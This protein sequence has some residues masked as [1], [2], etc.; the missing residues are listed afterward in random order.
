MPIVT[1]SIDL[2]EC[3]GS[4]KFGV[5]DVKKEADQE[6]IS[7]SS[8]KIDACAQKVKATAEKKKINLVSSSSSSSDIDSDDEPKTKN[9]STLP[10][11]RPMENTKSILDK[12][13]SRTEIPK[14]ASVDSFSES[15]TSSDDEADVRDT[16]LRLLLASKSMGPSTITSSK[17]FRPA[18]SSSDD[19]QKS[20]KPK[21]K[22]GFKLTNDNRPKKPKSIQSPAPV[23]A[24]NFESLFPSNVGVRSST[25]SFRGE[26]EYYCGRCNK[27]YINRKSVLNH[28]AFVHKLTDEKK[29]KILSQSPSTCATTDDSDGHSKKNVRNAIF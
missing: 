22:T 29:R 28:L 10:Q 9:S 5:T 2:F 20:T 23:T 7:A 25:K 13:R 17:K 18:S 27:P 6:K 24:S 26:V 21:S 11:K 12:K 16:K 14:M 3:P 4:P 8:K 15:A 19:E 1:K